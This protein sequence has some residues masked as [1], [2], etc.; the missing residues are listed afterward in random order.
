MNKKC[1]LLKIAHIKAEHENDLLYIN[2]AISLNILALTMKVTESLSNCL[3]S[4][5]TEDF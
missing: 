2:K 3:S 4:A 5:K 1:F